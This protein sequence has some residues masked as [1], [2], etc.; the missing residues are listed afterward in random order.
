MRLLNSTTN[1]FVNIFTPKWI[2]NI[3]NSYYTFTEETFLS[4]KVE[5]KTFIFI[6]VRNTCNL[7]EYIDV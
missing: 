5:N 4:K 6:T 2:A 3:K 1:L 7:I